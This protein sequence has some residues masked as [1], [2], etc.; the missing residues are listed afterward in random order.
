LSTRKD[1]FG[2][3][4]EPLRNDGYLLT[5]GFLRNDGEEP[6]SSHWVTEISR[7]KMSD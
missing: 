1:V 6:K 3:L 4:F 5:K 2:D 7:L